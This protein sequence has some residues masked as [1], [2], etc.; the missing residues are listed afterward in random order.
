MAA[1]LYHMA[2]LYILYGS[3]VYFIWQAY[4]HIMASLLLLHAYHITLYY[5]LHFRTPLNSFVLCVTDLLLQ[6]NAGWCVWWTMIRSCMH[7]AHSLQAHI[8]PHVSPPLEAKHCCTAWNH[9]SHGDTWFHA[10]GVRLMSCYYIYTSLY[11][12][13]VYIHYCTCHHLWKQ[14]TALHT[15]YMHWK[16]WTLNGTILYIIVL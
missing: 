4:S 16:H 8:L 6:N 14:N 15:T 10:L 11:K 2:P 1:T 5:Y 13:I 3:L 7:I 12:C 9:V